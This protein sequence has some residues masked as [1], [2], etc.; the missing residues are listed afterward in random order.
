MQ[1]FSVFTLSPELAAGHLIFIFLCKDNVCD[2][3]FPPKSS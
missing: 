3:S 1:D 2:V